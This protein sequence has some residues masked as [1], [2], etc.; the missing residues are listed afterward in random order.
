MF[1]LIGDTTFTK[2]VIGG[3]NVNAYDYLERIKTEDAKID[4]KRA[5][6]QEL[7][8]L[9]TTMTQNYSGMPKGSGN[10]DKMT[11]IVAKII[12]ARNR[13]NAQIDRYID[14]KQDAIRHIEMLP[15]RQYEVLHWLYIR[16]RINRE[17]NQSWYYTWSEI[18]D[19]MGCTEQNIGKLR[20][21]ALRNL[22]KIL[23]S[24]EKTEMV[25]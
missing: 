25:D 3:D 19:Y 4:A 23:D 11:V 21:K 14:A 16:K 2:L 8:A 5:E 9:A 15:L 10:D 20:K 22:Q 12:E 7:W 13:T 24:E 1:F 18:A 6:E 17:K